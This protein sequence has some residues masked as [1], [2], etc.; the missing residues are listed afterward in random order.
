MNRKANRLLTETSPYLL[1]HAYNPVNWYPW[2]E[3]ALQKAAAENKLLLVSIGYSA[4]HW[5]HVMEHESFEDEQVAEIMNDFFVCIKIDREE[6]P[7]IDQIYMYAV[8]LITG[9]GGWPLNCFC[10]PDQRPIYGGT[11][12]RKEDW[13][14]L[15][16]NL[17]AYWKDKPEEAI[18]YAVRLT[19]GIQ[20]SEQI[21]FI[22]QKTTYTEESLTEIFEP[23]K[24]RFDLT[25]GGYNRAP[26]FPLPNN[27]VFMLRYAHLMKDNTAQVISGITLEKMAF[28]GIYDHIGGGFS[29]YSVDERWH[30]PHFEKMLYDN[31]QLVSLYSEG[32][33]FSGNP[34]YKDVVFETL[35]WVKREMTSPEGGFYSALDA[36]S[37]G[38]EGKF[39]TY[40]KE[41]LKH[42]LGI[43][44]E[45]FS[46]Y[47]NVT[48]EGNWH[49]EH[50][51]I[52]FRKQDDETLATDIGLPVS[53][54]QEVIRKA[55]QKVFDHR[56]SRVRPGLDNKILAAWNGMMLKGY[57]DAYRAFSEVEFLNAALIN[58]RFILDNL[59]DDSG[60]LIRSFKSSGST[61]NT[62][63][64]DDYAFV[65]EGFISL[66]EV[67]FDEKW[68]SEAQK[69][70]RY[71]SE[72]FYDETTG[73]FY[74][75]SA[76]DKQLIA[77]KH[78]IT[79]NVI[80]SSNSVMAHNLYK[81]GHFY[82]NEEDTKTSLQMLQN[83]F[84]QIKSYGSAYSNWAN[85]LLNEFKG[86]YEIVIT[87]QN[88]ENKRKEL[89]KNYI[90]NKI[91]LGG[92]SGT[93]SLLK[94]KLG[95]QTR[96]FV[97]QNRTCLLPVTEITDALKQIG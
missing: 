57:T 40:S 17:A 64:L 80:P 58:A 13:K 33:Q 45:L 48:D 97:C 81:L 55:K 62:S 36:D 59:M 60:A 25:E 79:D 50:T 9:S 7:H 31:A 23:W 86:I 89:E 75:T 91:I 44:E 53:E 70:S 30:I 83:V 94:D 34:L 66:Y 61:G 90:P 87:G 27:W 84:P 29:R 52:F 37:E 38:V 51:N 32:Y 11:Y 46:I 3:E 77:R 69:L 26:K 95:D 42:I 1:Q 21:K 73:L 35:E 54:L 47:F 24:R 63:F 71:A 16:M 2:G 49:E 15:L 19:E 92:V 72:N 82:D 18:E 65:I 76:K 88:A 93:L 96:I 10:L 68:L 20:Q 14:N 43:E 78:E 5:C 85:L 39:Y 41:E 28:G 4:C 74:Y 12:F 6:R 56:S 8:Q 22:D 67:T